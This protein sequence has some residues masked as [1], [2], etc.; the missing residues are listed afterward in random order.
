MCS[1]ANAVGSTRSP[2][3]STQLPRRSNPLQIVWSVALVDSV[4][5]AVNEIGNYSGSVPIGGPG[6]VVVQADGAWTITKG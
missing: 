6:I 5:L 1:S 2:P 3:V 4:D